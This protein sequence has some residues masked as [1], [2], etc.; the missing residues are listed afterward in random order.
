MPF[1][2]PTLRELRERVL[3]D[4]Q[5]RLPGADTTL[6]RSNIQVTA[7]THAGATHGL[8]GHL[9]WLS[10]QLMPDTAE[11]DYLDRWAAIWGVGRKPASP[12][13]RSGS[14]TG[15]DGTVIP[16]GTVLRRSDGVQYTVD[17][18]VT[19]SEGVFALEF[20]ASQAGETGNLTPGATLAFLSPIVGITS[21]VT[22]LEGGVDGVDQESDTEL[23]HR[24]LSRIQ[25][26]PHGGHAGDY[27]KWALECPGV[28][29]AWVYSNHLGL[30]TVGIIF[31][32]DGKAGTI[33]PSQ[34][35]V[36]AVAAHIEEHEDPLTGRRVGRPVT[37]AVTVMA[38]VADP[39]DLTIHLSPDTSVV[40][41]AVLA[42]LAD[43][44]MREGEP[45]GTLL[46]SHIREA[47]STA[48]GENDH[49]VQSPADNLTFEAGHIP[50]MG[51]VTWV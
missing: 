47:V 36:D 39:V 5:T 13:R 50:V 29:R 20:T 48:T 43:L 46:I 23:L 17:A 14:G 42:N 26:P 1:Q 28:T 24:L 35:E 34:D 41:A 12:A 4:F 21:T 45:G 10:L 9:D 18:E 3:S 37:A 30:G 32:M 38:P 15:A 7:I 16:A 27:A 31:V 49:V 19:V 51:T 6:R 40:R 33:I 8:H 11:Q 44:V 25:A 2:R 22:V